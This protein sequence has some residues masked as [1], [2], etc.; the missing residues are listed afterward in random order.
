MRAPRKRSSE[1]LHESEGRS[2]THRR[3]KK[4]STKRGVP[5]LSLWECGI[6]AVLK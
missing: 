5:P 6:G 3:R 1:Q 2:V 4:P